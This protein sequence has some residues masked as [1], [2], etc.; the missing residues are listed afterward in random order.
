MKVVT[1]AN[2]EIPYKKVSV[3][4]LTKYFNKKDI[5]FI[6]LEENK[7]NYNNVHPS[8]W[9]CHV[10]KLFDDDFIVTWD[11]D[12]IPVNFE[13]DLNIIF[14]KNKLNMTYDS[15]TIFDRTY[16]NQNFKYNCG[17][18]GIPKC[19]SD[20]I[21]KVYD[22][23]SLG[24]YGSWEQYYVNDEI[25]FQNKDVNLIPFEYNFLHLP[26]FY[27]MNLKNIINKYDV[28]N[29]HFTYGVP[30]SEYKK[31]LIEQI[32]KIYYENF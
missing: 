5:E 4:L 14:D 8:W 13:Y 22:K 2:G 16:F 25:V 23:H 30:S 24:W 31:I 29:F 3:E 21:E 32:K 12:M 18:M 26:R 27:G 15:G 10:H 11:L 28:K 1:I 17:F 19:E 9:K 20:F 6:V 7:F